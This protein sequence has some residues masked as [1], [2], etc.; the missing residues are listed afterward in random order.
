MAWATTC[1]SMLARCAADE[2]A[3][4]LIE[5]A[6]MATN[7]VAESAPRPTIALDALGMCTGMVLV[8][9]GLAP[10]TLLDAQELCRVPL[11]W[12]CDGFWILSFFA[13]SDAF[14]ATASTGLSC[15]L[16]LVVR[17]V[18]WDSER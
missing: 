12:F 11:G 6:Y 10:V 2:V 13:H 5:E 16:L 14:W 3:G 7:R 4:W 18:G 8:G 15:H 9:L 1:A 17:S